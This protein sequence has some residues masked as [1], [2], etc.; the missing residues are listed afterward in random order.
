MEIEVATLVLSVVNLI[1]VIAMVLV[2]SLVAARVVQIRDVMTKKNGN[3]RQPENDELLKTMAAQV[4]TM[5]AQVSAMEREFFPKDGGSMSFHINELGKDA[6]EEK[7]ARSKAQSAVEEAKNAAR[8]A[9]ESV[10]RGE[11]Y[12]RTLQTSVNE[13]SILV[14]SA[15][16]AVK[17]VQNTIQ[18]TESK[19]GQLTAGNDSTQ[20][21][22]SFIP[23]P[24]TIVEQTKTDIHTENIKSGGVEQA[25]KGLGTTKEGVEQI[26]KG[27]EQLKGGGSTQDKT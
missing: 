23:A 14:A 15:R 7:T 24:A 1:G 2:I 21:K 3:V 4:S 11:G 10:T 6:V 16:E 9:Q 19:I 20:T 13:V 27:I 17:I 18:A 5:A 26:E 12:L 25:S 8:L 22:T